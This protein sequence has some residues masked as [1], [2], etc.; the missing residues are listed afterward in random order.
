MELDNTDELYEITSVVLP[1]G[2]NKFVPNGLLGFD[3][4]KVYVVPNYCFDVVYVGPNCCF[5]SHSS[6]E[7]GNPVQQNAV[8]VACATAANEL[9]NFVPQPMQQQNVAPQQP[10]QQQNFVPQQPMQQQ[11]VAP[12]QPMQQ[13]NFAPQP[14]QQ[15]LVQQAQQQLVQLLRQL[16]GIVHAQQ[17]YEER[18][19]RGPDRGPD[20]EFV[21][22]EQ[23]REQLAQAYNKD[24][25]VRQL[26][27]QLQ[28]QWQLLLQQFDSVVRARQLWEKAWR[29]EQASLVRGFI[30][31]GGID[32]RSFTLTK[33]MREQLAQAYN[34]SESRLQQFQ[35]QPQMLSLQEFQLLQ[36]L[37][38]CGFLMQAQDGFI[39]VRN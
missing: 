15:H 11:N 18:E 3:K 6:V 26:V 37:I 9:Q 29:K 14:V 10:A 34:R 35:P 24:E 22:T 1:S 12:Q 32:I 13:Q 16:N 5:D 25:S 31:N 36:E 8:Q 17:S 2:V 27:Q 23:K 4:T 28:P 20:G 21:L 30:D 38:A 7:G 33:E 19:F 39:L